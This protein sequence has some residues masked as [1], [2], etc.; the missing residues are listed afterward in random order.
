MPRQ[1]FS[2]PHLVIPRE[3]F[4]GILREIDVIGRVCINKI[5]WS[6][7]HGFE[8]IIREFPIL[9]HLSVGAKIS[10]V[11]DPFVLTKWHIELSAAIKPAQPI[12]TGAVQIIKK[13][14][15][16][17]GLCSLIGQKLIESLA[18]RIK[19]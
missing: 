19:Q 18:M 16:F 14:C 10:C 7:R 13:F 3:A 1:P 12:K 5:I 17:G 11:I 9:K 6:K 8:V 2:C 4:L 15:S